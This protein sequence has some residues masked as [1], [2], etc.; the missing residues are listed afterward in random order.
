VG[1]T[2]KGGLPR[3]R[4][5]RGEEGAVSLGCVSACWAS[6]RAGG[7]A[8]TGP[9]FR[10]EKVGR[11]ELLGNCGVGF[12]YFW[13]EGGCAEVVPDAHR[14]GLVGAGK[15]A[16]TGGGVGADSRVGGMGAVG[17]GAMGGGGL[18]SGTAV[19]GSFV[20]KM[21]APVPFDLS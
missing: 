6:Y 4:G 21:K 5:D 1:V 14:I 17:A 2:L 20:E 12:F 15:S 8:R 3:G 11:G 10:S 16:S 7:G 19:G 13:V 9:R 18:G